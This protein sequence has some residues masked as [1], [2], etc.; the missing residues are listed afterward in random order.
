MNH[1]YTPAEMSEE[2]VLPPGLANDW[3]ARG[4]Y[5]TLSHNAKAVYQSLPGLV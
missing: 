2:L 4:Y 1:G 3:A 5:G